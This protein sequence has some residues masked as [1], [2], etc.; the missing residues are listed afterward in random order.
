MTSQSSEKP[1][2]PNAR[3]GMFS[4]QASQ[5][6]IQ[7]RLARS[8][9]LEPGEGYRTLLLS[10]LLFVAS[11]IFV[12]GR[13]VRDALFLTQFSFDWIAYLGIVYGGASATVALG[14]GWMSGFASRKRFSIVFA[15]GAAVTYLVA[16]GAIVVW[17]SSAIA[18]FYVWA[19]VIGNLFVIQAWAIANDL[20][21]P[22]SARRLFGYV[23]AGRVFG[24]LA[25]GLTTS[26]LVQIIG[27]AN[28]ICV[29][30]VLMLVFA[31]LVWYI[32]R[33]YELPLADKLRPQRTTGGSDGRREF[34][35]H[36]RYVFLLAAM[37]LLM[38]FALTI[39][40]YQFKSI[41]KINY[42]NRDDLASYMGFFYGAMGA[43]AVVFQL[44]LTPRILKNFGVLH[45]LLAIPTAFLLSTA[46]LIAWPVISIAT[47]LKLSDNGLQYTIHDATMQL[48]YFAF[49]PSL[50][51]RVR[52]LLDAAVKPIGYSLA[53][54]MLVLVSPASGADQSAGAL[55]QRIANIGYVTL[56]VG[57]VW[58]GL[59]P[60]VRRAYVDVLRRSLVRRQ[61]DVGD[62]LDLPLDAST[63]KVLV[64]TLRQGAPAQV[65]FAFERLTVS[66]PKQAKLALPELLE[67][68]SATVRAFALT[69]SVLLD[70]QQAMQ[71]A[72][73]YL[74]DEHKEV[75]RAAIVTL[76]AV[77]Q[78][79]AV[80]EIE[81]YAADDV[82]REVRDAAIVTMIDKGGLAGVLAGGQHLQQMLQSDNEQLRA[83]GAAIL[84]QVGRPGLARTLI[85]LLRDPS[86]MVRRAAATAARQCV[87][88]SLIVPL[89]D[90]MVERGLVKPLSM[91]LVAA[92]PRA[93]PA[94]RERLENE[95][96]P[97]WVRLN[98]PRILHGIGGMECLQ[99]LRGC[100]TTVDEGVRQKCL[101]SASRLRAELQAP[102][103]LAETL[104]PMIEQEVADHVAVR[105]GYIE[106]RKWFARPLLDRQIQRELRGHVARIL[107]LCEQA[108]PLEQVAAARA[109]VFS[110]D[111]ARRANGLELLDNVLNRSNRVAI[112]DI[113]ARYGTDCQFVTSPRPSKSRPSARV[114]AWFEARINLPGHYRRALLLD[115]V[116]Y[117]QRCEFA[118]SAIKYVSSDEPF[119][120]ENAL[121]VLAVCQPPG[122][123]EYM[124]A[125]REDAHPVVRAYANY[126]LEMRRTGLD[127]EDE[128][129]TTVEKILYLQGVPLFSGISGNDL[130]PLAMRARVMRLAPGDVLFREKDAGDALYVVF[131]GQV[132]LYR[133]EQQVALL[134]EGE[135]AGELAILDQAPR[136]LTAVAVGDVDVLRVSGEDFRN[137]LQD[138]AEFA[139]GVISVLAKRLRDLMD[140]T[141]RR[142]K[143]K[144]EQSRESMIGESSEEIGALEPG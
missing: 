102:P 141:D 111:P 86:L 40:D 3:G 37:V 22:R 125:A 19:E 129:Y 49:P 114:K 52:V 137:T 135:V 81:P 34:Q 16:R 94:L 31:L 73:Q 103:L 32:N 5:E 60:F 100:F 139:N 55:A 4:L 15:V 144:Q 56:A 143:R 12:M 75:R 24:I 39:G 8:F 80:E 112:L 14:Y 30:A 89:L 36:R 11:M 57:V 85:P 104:G 118:E 42:P 127:M 107:R 69:Q 41:A 105:D 74:Q 78:E 117:H 131:H 90:A 58:V 115:A 6:L 2:V 9:A 83:E 98:I 45:G 71:L 20:H 82:H 99:I 128:M 18:V 88:H 79:D 142:T 23:G 134:G 63:Q 68:K 53:G 38:F 124:Q 1:S 93:V 122:W 70:P 59:V 46:S 106:V 21:N 133:D 67:H 26:W 91:A 44:F 97:R 65:V 17:T 54:V 121:I 119:M 126:V 7:R 84:G 29:L 116:A 62:E 92:G 43:V 13:T 87:H 47:V 76:G 120:R 140:P 28:L 51:T 136:M 132:A 138:T 130:M 50:R 108:Y 77:G 27:T 96:T 95:R 109:G 10:V 66:A 113:V 33:C 123:R 48:V 64:E 72:R 110:S 61:S 101:A 35:R 25:S